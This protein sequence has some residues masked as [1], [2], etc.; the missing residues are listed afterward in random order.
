MSRSKKSNRGWSI[1][2]GYIARYKRHVV[3]YSILGVISAATNGFLPLIFGAFFDAILSNEQFDY[4]GLSLPLWA[5]LLIVGG[6]AQA[7]SNI[8]EWNND[9]RARRIGTYLS[10]Q[11]ATESVARMIRMPLG[12]YKEQKAGSV[13]NKISRARNYLTQIVESVVL[14]VA[15]QILSV[16]VGFVVAF[17][18]NPFLA[19][20]ILTGVLLYILALTQVVPPLVKLQRKGEQAWSRAYGYAYDSLFN[21]QPIKQAGAED[22]ESERIRDQFIN[23]VSKT[24][25]GVEKIWS[26]ISFYQSILITITR[27]SVFVLSVYFIQEGSLTIG[28]LMALNGYAAMVFGPFVRIGYQWQT[29]QVGLVTIENSEKLLSSP[30]ENYEPQ[31]AVSFKKS[32]GEIEF[33]N[34]SFAY[35]SGGGKILNNISFKINP[36]EV[37]AIMGESGVGKTT[38]IDLIS[39]YYVP[40]KGKILIDGYDIANIRLR[41]LRSNIA[42]VPQEVVL[43]NDNVKNNIRYGNFSA[44]DIQIKQVA[45]E[46]NADLFIEKFPKKYQQLVGERGV[47]L[48]VGQKQRVAIARAILR[49]PKILILDEPTS[50]L[51]VQTEKQITAS[52]ER[53]MRGRTTIIIAHRFSTVRKADRILMFD[54]GKLAEQGTHKDLIA[55][56]GGLYK[57]LYDL[58]AGFV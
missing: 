9:I 2:F 12:L 46:A 41:D 23:K 34:V 40:D 7:I 44:S 11:Y 26:G 21:I 27:M 36:G 3:I 5:A 16:A 30:P 17:F 10:S 55:K 14:H 35:K 29:I 48:S 57:K 58:H 38:L 1:M 45:K 8:V 18:I 32:M 49:N 20:L 6:I 43:F 42:V 24:W 33:R 19:G 53:L 22:Y 15:P 52:L 31:N 4:A 28:G 25:F 13:W 54:K 47:K 51:D 37:V 56:R 39:R 50:A